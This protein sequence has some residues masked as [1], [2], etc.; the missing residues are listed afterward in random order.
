MQWNDVRVLL[1]LLRARSLAEA[2]SALGID[3]TTTG[4]H[5]AALEESLGARLFV[6]TREGLRPTPAA[7]RLRAHAEQMEASANALT[8]AAASGD[9]SAA[10]VVRVATTE[11]FA[12]LLVRHGL[13]EISA[14]HPDLAVELLAENRPV[15]LVR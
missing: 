3:R 7:E 1:A 12:I 2:G 15:D 8:S 4:R 9:G 5:L 13:A 6:R 14:Q 10:G 11:A